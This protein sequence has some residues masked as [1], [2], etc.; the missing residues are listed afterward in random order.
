[1]P[2]QQRPRTDPTEDWQQ[3][4]LL[5]KEPAQRTYEL[6]RPVVLFGRSPA[7]RARQ[8]GAAE[9]TLYRQAARFDAHGMAGLL[10][11]TAEQQQRRLPA[12]VRQAILQLK[13]E[14]PPFRPQEL[15]SIIEVRFGY[16][17]SHHTIKRLVATETLPAPPAR[18]FAPYHQIADP[19]A[20]RLAIIRLHAEG[21]NIKSIAA[22]LQT[23][24]QTVYTTLQRWIAEGVAGLD[25]KSHARQDGVRK[26]DLRTIAAIRELQAN[27]ELG[28]WRVH[29]AL[30][31]EGIEVSP[32]TC[33]R[34]LA[35]NRALYGLAKPS[36]SPR[37]PQPMPFAAGRRHQY[38]TVDLRYLDMHQLGGGNIYVISILENY[39][40]ALLASGLS[41][42]QDL[43]AYLLVLYVALREHGSPEAIVSDGGAIFR[44]TDLL[45]IYEA[46]GIRRE[47]IDP[48]Q[49][50][51]SYIETH[52]NV[53]RRLTDWHVSQATS[54]DE[55]LAV[56]ERWVEEY[57]S[58]D[59]WA[60][61]ARAADQRSPAVVLRWVKGRGHDS[62]ALHRAFSA[63]RVGRAV[64]RLGYVRVR[65]WR[66][67]GERGLAG[68]RATV[69]LYGEHLTIEY[70]DEVLA[71][72]RVAYQPNGRQL[73]AVTEP[74]LFSTP[75]QSA[76]PTLWPLTD[77]EWLKALRLTPAPAQPRR[78]RAEVVQERLFS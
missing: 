17:V 27:P 34:I 78:H 29:A 5:V 3:L 23:S 63:G 7:E 36:R 1:M 57:N 35:R 30:K 6:I 65:R 70:K 22:Y 45:T 42:T 73:R 2:A 25:D 72:Y 11:P 75:F 32:R 64:D 62:E 69:W 53:M 56:H 54:W 43:G 74:R 14:H 33:S 60:H 38:W 8:T 40:R 9:R 61:R 48:G 19:A 67:Y 16:S 15:V 58:Q 20:R 49:P 52:F 21:W 71:Q 37:A 4:A 41:R 39:S 44:A 18:R 50:W 46:L 31:R 66:V 10:P 26:V 13:A 55:L 28:E 12:E 68:E 59:H 76:Q 24:R 77:A 47:Q 51:Q